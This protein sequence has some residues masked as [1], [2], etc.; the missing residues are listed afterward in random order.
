MSFVQF[1]LFNRNF[2]AKFANILLN[3]TESMLSCSDKRASKWPK[4]AQQHMQTL[5]NNVNT[6]Q[7]KFNLNLHLTFFEQRIQ[8]PR[9][10]A[11]KAILVSTLTELLRRR[12]NWRMVLWCFVFFTCASRVRQSRAFK[13]LLKFKNILLKYFM[14]VI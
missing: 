12:R 11:V 5:L 7:K 6:S 9:I 1:E 10:V 8:L 2:R 13:K 3:F 14:Q 4:N